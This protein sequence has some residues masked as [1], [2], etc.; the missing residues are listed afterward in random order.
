MNFSENMY[1]WIPQQFPKFINEVNVKLW[2]QYSL[3][4]KRGQ[5]NIII[6]KKLG[7]SAKKKKLF[8]VNNTGILCKA[9]K[10]NACLLH[11]HLITF[12]SVCISCIVMSNLTK[13][14]QMYQQDGQTIVRLA[15]KKSIA[16]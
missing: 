15:E 13:R 9:K 2:F 4:Q 5:A 11:Q 12:A 6:T 14:K 16:D 10:K 1:N 3:L 7:V 8:E